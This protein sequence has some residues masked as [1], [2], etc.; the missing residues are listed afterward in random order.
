[1]TEATAAGYSPY[2]FRRKVEAIA[3]WKPDLIKKSIIADKRHIVYALTV[4]RPVGS[5]CLSTEPD[6]I[7]F[8]VIT[9]LRRRTTN[10]QSTAT[11]H[12]T[13]GLPSLSRSSSDSSVAQPSC[14][15]AVRL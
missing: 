7:E 15:A 9:S 5:L 2:A 4:E 11:S 12:G 14:R 3:I 13:R 1:M 6:N 8:L 10:V